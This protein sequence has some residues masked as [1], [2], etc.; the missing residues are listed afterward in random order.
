[1]DLSRMDLIDEN[2]NWIDS[3]NNQQS[4]PYGWAGSID[5]RVKGWDKESRKE[6]ESW[7]KDRSIEFHNVLVARWV[8]LSVVRLHFRKKLDLLLVS[9]VEG[10]E[11]AEFSN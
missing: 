2:L 4:L 1:M 10:V 3:I 5:V 6:F 7:L 11:N 8:N 9:L